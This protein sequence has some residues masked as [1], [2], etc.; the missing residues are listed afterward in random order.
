MRVALAIQEDI[1]EVSPVATLKWAD[2]INLSRQTPSQKR[3]DFNPV[4]NNF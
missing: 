2:T 1:M 3:I 4:E